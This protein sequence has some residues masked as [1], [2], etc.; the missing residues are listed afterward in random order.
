MKRNYD[1]SVY[2]YDATRNKF[3]GKERDSE[4]GLKKPEKPGKNRGQTGKTGDRRD[5]L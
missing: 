5:V 4:S 1:A 3:T 2:N